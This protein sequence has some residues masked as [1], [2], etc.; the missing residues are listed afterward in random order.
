MFPVFS[1]CLLIKSLIHNYMVIKHLMTTSEDSYILYSQVKRKNDFFRECFQRIQWG[2][3][4]GSMIGEPSKKKKKKLSTV[5]QTRLSRGH[6]SNSRMGTVAVGFSETAL[7]HCFTGGWIQSQNS[8]GHT[9]SRVVS[10]YLA[11]LDAWSSN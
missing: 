9:H 8:W 1:D 11:E 2:A 7:V 3:D 6:H 10:Q 4:E 5:K